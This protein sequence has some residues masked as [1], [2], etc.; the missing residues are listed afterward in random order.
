MPSLDRILISALARQFGA[1]LAVGIAAAVVHFGLL[2]GMVEGLRA[3]P[4]PA[5]LGGYVAGGVISYGLNRRLTYRSDR[6]H[7]QAT[8][9]FTLVALV[10]F[11]LT[12]A[13]M[14]AFTR[15]LGVPY[16]PAQVATTGVVLFWS[17]AANKAWTFGKAR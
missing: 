15:S 17:F 1:F 4:V 7:A 13:F 16:V 10:G 3:D 11:L 5:T 14:H 8:W 6:P 2:I 12:W 9:R